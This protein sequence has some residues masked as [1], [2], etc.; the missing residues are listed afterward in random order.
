M[1]S[2]SLPEGTRLNSNGAGDAYLSG[3][4]VA[5]MLRHTGK[6]LAEKVDECVAARRHPVVESPEKKNDDKSITSPVKKMTPYTLY[7]KENYVILKQECGGD[8][9]SIFTKC[10][11]MWENEREDV[12][13]MYGR[14]V[15]EE[16]VDGATETS[17]VNI[18]DISMDAVESNLSGDYSGIQ[19]GREQATDACLNLESAVQLAGLIAARHV[20]MS[21]R[22][23]DQLDFT[24]LLE[25]AIISLLPIPTNEE[26]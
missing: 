20:D 13:A 23:L 8:K 17:T 26:I 18:S 7:M 24:I 3:L 22:D 9:K 12:K 25:R 16:Y 6:S 4:L 15:N 5:S 14:M 21:T 11:E 1:P 2:S 10:H 19:F